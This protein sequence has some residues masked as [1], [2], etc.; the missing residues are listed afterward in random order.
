MYSIISPQLLPALAYTKELEI[1]SQ[2]GR[3][4]HVSFLITSKIEIKKMKQQRKISPTVVV[5]FLVL[6]MLAGQSTGGFFFYKA[7]YRLLKG[8][9]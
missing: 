7:N 6:G 8:L 5:Y 3:H 4:I 2:F 9:S 1:Q